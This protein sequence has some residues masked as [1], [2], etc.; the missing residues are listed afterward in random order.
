MS[1]KD[2][3]KDYERIIKLEDD[4]YDS[5]IL[6][7]YDVF[8][9]NCIKFAE[10]NIIPLSKYSNELDN[11]LKKCI[12][13]LENKISKAELEKY[14]CQLGKKIRLS[15]ILDSKEKEIHTFM[16]IFLDYNFLQNTPPEDQQDSDICYLLCILY[17]IK[18]N[19]E[20]CNKFYNF[21]SKQV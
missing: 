17:E 18:N 10:E 2:N 16:S 20:L 21:I 5:D 6:E 9:L 19:L 7:N 12:A 11:I 4:I 3:A 8:I 13:F 15:G 1:E 14:Y